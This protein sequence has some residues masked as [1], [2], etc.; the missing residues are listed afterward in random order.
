M[1]VAHPHHSFH[2]DADPDSDP[3]HLRDAILQ[4]LVYW[5]SSS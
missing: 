4:Q 3:P 1:Q 2:F 5:P